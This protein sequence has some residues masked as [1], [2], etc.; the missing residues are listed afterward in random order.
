M[1][2][3]SFSQI[4]PPE[5][6]ELGLNIQKQRF[7]G[8]NGLFI[9]KKK[10]GRID[11]GVGANEMSWHVDV[12]FGSFARFGY[13]KLAE[14]G[15]NCKKYPIEPGVG[16]GGLGLLVFHNYF[17]VLS[18]FLPASTGKFCFYGDASSNVRTDMSP[19][20]L[21]IYEML[22][23]SSNSSPLNCVHCLENGLF[24]TSL[25]QPHYIEEL[26]FY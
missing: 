13:R 17:L 18:S 25:K 10:N 20:V 21:L 4:R 16:V 12:P 22:S 1:P 14:Y 15:Q 24:N 2:F 5:M 26:R 19:K 9:C 23:L 3:G 7:K 8:F 6:A 11:V